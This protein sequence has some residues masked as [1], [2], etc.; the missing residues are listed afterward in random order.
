MDMRRIVGD[1]VRAAR[2]AA[3]MTQEQLAARSGYSQ[4]YLNQIEKGTRNPTIVAIYE[5]G[6]AMGVSHEDLVR[7]PR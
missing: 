4:Q 1:N 6:Q 3:G 5:I 2:L 7:A